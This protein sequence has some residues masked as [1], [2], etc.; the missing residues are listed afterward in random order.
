MNF[1]V[2]LWKNNNNN[3]MMNGWIMTTMQEKKPKTWFCCSSLSCWSLIVNLKI[4]T[5][6]IKKQKQQQNILYVLMVFLIIWNRGGKKVQEERLIVQIKNQNKNNSSSHVYALPFTVTLRIDQ[7][8]WKTGMWFSPFL[9]L[10]FLSFFDVWELR[11]RQ[12][13]A[14][15][16]WVKHKQS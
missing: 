6:M 13:S 3:N 9:F 10:L 4:W 7:C 5:W 14:T 12:A 8:E 15:N 16:K 11:C 2:T 1:P